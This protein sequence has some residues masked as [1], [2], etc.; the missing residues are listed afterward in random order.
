MIVIFDDRCVLG[1]NVFMQFCLGLTKGQTME[2]KQKMYSC[3]CFSN[4]EKN[5]KAFILLDACGHVSKILYWLAI[6]ALPLNSKKMNE[7]MYANMI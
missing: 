5:F 3:D 7:F 1:E 6:Y 2:R 4:T